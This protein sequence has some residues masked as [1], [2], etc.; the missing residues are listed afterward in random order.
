MDQPRTVCRVQPRG[1]NVG[2]TLSLTRTLSVRLASAVLKGMCGAAF[3]RIDRSE[4][5][6]CE[7]R[8]CAGQGR[9]HEQEDSRNQGLG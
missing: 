2:G 9:T 5:C 8:I 3:E 6:V 1:H 7:I 4:G